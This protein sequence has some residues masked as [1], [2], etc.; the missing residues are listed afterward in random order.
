MT[1]K[2]ILNN[3]FKSFGKRPNSLIGSFAH[4]LIIAFLFFGVSPSFSQQYNLRNYSVSEGLAQSQVFSIVE[5]TH[6]FIWMGTRGG[7]IS[8][9]DGLQFKNYS[10]KD[11]LLNDYIYDLKTDKRGNLWIATNAG[12]SRFDGKKFKNFKL[13]NDSLNTAVL[14]MCFDKDS[15]LWL[16]TDKNLYRIKNEKVICFSCENK[17]NFN[18]L[19]TVLIDHTN[20]LWAGDDN[21]L[22]KVI[23]TNNERT[24]G[25]IKTFAQMEGLKNIHVRSLYESK[26]KNILV[27]TY[28]GGLFI[29]D[30]IKCK[31]LS[32]QFELKDKIIHKVIEDKNGDVWMATQDNGISIWK[33]SDSSLVYITK[34]EGLCNDHTSAILQDSWGNLWFGSSG[35]GVSRFSGQMFMHYNE[36]AGVKGNY[37]FAVKMARDSSLWIGTMAKGVIHL[38]DGISKHYHLDSGFID[39]K[40]KCIYEDRKGRMWFG[41]EGKGLWAKDTSGFFQISTREGLSSNWIKSIAEDNQGIL[42]IGTAGGGLSVMSFENRFQYSVKRIKNELMPERLNCLLKD[43]DKIWYGADLGRGAGFF[44]RIVQNI[45]FKGTEVNLTPVKQLKNVTI[46]AIRKSKDFIWMATAGKGVLRIS[47]RD[48]KFSLKYFNDKNGLT[49]NNIYLLEV[50]KEGNL[51]AGSENGI[52]KL[53]LSKNGDLLSVKHYGRNEGFIGIETAQNAACKGVNGELWFGTISGLTKFNPNS[54]QKN[55]RAPKLLLS[56]MSLLYVELEKT[57]YASFV[58]KFGIPSSEIEFNYSDNHLS[59]DFIGINHTNP[60][61]VMYQ[62]K[63]EGFENDWSPLTTKSDAT[64]PNIAPG[65]Y[66][67]MVKACNE[68]G[69]CNEKPLE[70]PF[71]ILPPYWQTLWFRLTIIIGSILL[72]TLIILFFVLRSRRRN[73]DLREKL[74]ME[75]NLLQLEQKALRLQMN[76]HF[77]FHALNSIQGLIVQKDEKTARNYLSKFSKLMR[78]I[79]ENSREQSITL[80]T[81][82]ATL[83]NY[84]E[85]EKFTRGDT[86]DFEVNCDSEIDQN[87]IL[88]PPMLLQP[89][90]ENAIIHG[91]NGLNRRGKINVEFHFVILSP[92]EGSKLKCIIRDNGVGREK[93]TNVKIQQESEHKS[94]ALKVTQERLDMLNAGEKSLFIIDIK[95]ENGNPAGTEIQ[96]LIGVG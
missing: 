30:G 48:E 82:I 54:V 58:N 16:A 19:S 21:G 86:F 76:P 47:F 51:W 88:I 64:Y 10:S 41:T 42:W 12:V 36:S 29:F 26:N 57:P 83:K 32:D 60:E 23:F 6:G 50:D 18:V 74:L 35:G 85:L 56:Q 78:S 46:R 70:I 43:G 96:I 90:V 24:K 45:D 40:V 11:G 49:S 1:K 89:F 3:E 55:N 77:I 14:E 71:T 95:D 34:N 69:V 91:F 31:S 13:G 2:N 38:K 28:G 53:V 66:I 15:N 5:D 84:L 52:D 94:T 27:A 75:K 25:K 44:Q 20:T 61:R 67:F 33:P 72:V 81:E 62:W 73:K 93:A 65:N 87:D 59:F 17:I 7:G 68:D 8:R 39:E 79:L 9:F 22:N 63:L 80:E 37:V 92:S 4:S